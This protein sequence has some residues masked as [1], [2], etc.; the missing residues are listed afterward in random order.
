MLGLHQ[1]WLATRLSELQSNCGIAA[2]VAESELSC[3]GDYTIGASFSS[4]VVVTGSDDV[5]DLIGTIRKDGGAIV[6][7]D[8]SS[9]VTSSLAA[10]LAVAYPEGVLTLHAELLAG[11]HHKVKVYDSASETLS[12]IKSL[13]AIPSYPYDPAWCL[14]GTFS[15]SAPSS[16]LFN[17][18]GVFPTPPT[19]SGGTVSL[20]S[21][22]KTS[23]TLLIDQPVDDH[24]C[25]VTAL[26]GDTTN[27]HET[28]GGGREVVVVL[29]PEKDAKGNK[30]VRVDF[31]YAQNPDC[32]FTSVAQC[33]PPRPENVLAFAVRAG[34]RAI[35]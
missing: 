1:K 26:F 12:Q 5:P 22:T 34:E 25:E 7:R 28:F 31:N 4:D 6:F 27:G 15:R 33:H 29:L 2:L 24:P 8:E 3:N 19:S 20:I 17:L 16:T 30:R 18:L 10:Q 14:E 13:N 32:A 21:P 23:F 11:G 9:G 35:D